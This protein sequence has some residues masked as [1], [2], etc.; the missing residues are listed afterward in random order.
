MAEGCTRISSDN[1]PDRK[2]C[3]LRDVPFL[4]LSVICEVYTGFLDPKAKKK[5][6]RVREAG[7]EKEEIDVGE[8][9][10]WRGT[11]ISYQDG[12]DETKLR[13]AQVP[14]DCCTYYTV[15]CNDHHALPMSA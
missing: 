7:S 3:R 10:L 4:R 15:L 11:G 9:V 6:R 2:G 13:P 12:E 8:R 1:F 5:N 14:F